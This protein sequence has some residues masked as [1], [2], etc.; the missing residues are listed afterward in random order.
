MPYIILIIGKVFFTNNIIS[1][2]QKQGE[3]QSFSTCK[4]DYCLAKLISQIYTTSV[5]VKVVLVHSPVGHQSKY[6]TS[7]TN[8]KQGQFD[9]FKHLNMVRPL[10]VSP[11]LEIACSY[12]TMAV[13]S[14]V[15]Q[16]HKWLLCAA[17]IA[18]CKPMV[19]LWWTWVM[20]SKQSVL[21]CLQ[22]S[23]GL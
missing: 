14:N 21:P 8:R 12:N 11:V 15:Y 13:S 3:N 23:L 16:A 5:W 2:K 22:Y 19:S 6:E 7:T 18:P 20:R 10:M 1:Q 4:L 17:H 9:L